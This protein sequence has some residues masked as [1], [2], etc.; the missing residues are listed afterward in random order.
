MTAKEY[1]S[2][3]QTYRRAVQTYADRIEELY[4]D[5]SGLKAIVY[6][7]DRVQVSP[8]NKLE[9]IFEK[10]DREAEKYAKARVRYEVEVQKR[11][12]Q[13]AGLDR[14]EHC[15]I[16]RL[17]YVELEEDGNWK[18]VPSNTAI[19]DFNDDRSN[20]RMEFTYELEGEYV[21]SVTIQHDWNSVFILSPLG[22]EPYKLACSILLAQEGCGFTELMEKY[23]DRI[24]FWGGISTQK[25]L[26]YGTP[27]EVAE[28]TRR[29]TAALAENGGYIIAPAQEI[30][31]DV[32]FEN[33]CALIDTANAL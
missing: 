23:G 2:K 14:P 9:K 25:T 17:R 1:L 28:E 10:I 6:N 31:A 33:L 27:E 29:L 24:A 20:H 19:V 26:P 7:K 4:H 22:D 5:A 18:P 16:L 11:V 3:I 12:D 21:K 13:I 30:Q 15:E 32:P 8:E